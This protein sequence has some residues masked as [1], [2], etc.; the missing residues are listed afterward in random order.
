MK[1]AFTVSVLSQ[2][3]VTTLILIILYACVQQSYRTGADDPQIQIAREVAGR[4]STGR[5]A[6]LFFTGDSLDLS[7]SGSV[8]TSLYNSA[9]KPVKAT[10]F[11]NGKMPQMPSGVFDFANR[12]GE[13]R[14]SWQP[15]QGVRIAMVIE[16]VSSP[17]I[18]Y[19]GVGRSLKEVEVRENNLS[20]MILIGWILCVGILLINAWVQS[21]HKRI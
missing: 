20:R 10:G 16:K 14:I 8:F 4:L 5:T 19:V 11:L 21:K 1:Y 13:N 2:L 7:R 6:D 9:G 17:G 12:F 3:A 18:G 15:Q